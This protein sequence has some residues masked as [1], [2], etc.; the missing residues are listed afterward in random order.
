M[1]FDAEALLQQ[2]G[3]AGKHLVGGGGGD[4]NQINFAG[5]QVG[6]FDGFARRLL[7]EVDGE[8]II[9][10]NPA[11]ADAGARLDPLLGGVDHGFEFLVGEDF[12]G[13]VSAR[14]D[15]S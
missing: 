6:R 10:R 12:V 11:L 14:A 7:G 9:R 8:F 15:D 3:G 4:H 5:A 1:P 13:Q 2:A